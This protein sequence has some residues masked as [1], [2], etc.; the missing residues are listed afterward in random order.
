MAE[1]VTRRACGT[2]AAAFFV[3][4]VACNPISGPTSLLS[5]GTIRVDHSAPADGATELRVVVG[6]DPAIPRDKRT[7]ALHAS[8]GTFEGKSDIS[9]NA[10]DADSVVT[11]LRAPSQV[12]TALITAMIGSS[13][14]RA[15]VAFTRAYPDSLTLSAGKFTLDTGITTTT[16]ITATL[17]RLVGK[18]TAGATV[19]FAAFDT[20]VTAHRHGLLSQALPSDTNG[21]VTVSYSSGDNAFLGQI[22]IVATTQGT[23]GPIKDTL[24]LQVRQPSKSVVPLAAASRP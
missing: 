16:T 21:Q 6:V 18:P 22:W 23:S 3:A 5:V 9:L 20:I 24:V 10:G 4:A 2:G 19:S 12:D 7:V 14:S 1:R 8:A 17:R 13:I 11:L 15:E